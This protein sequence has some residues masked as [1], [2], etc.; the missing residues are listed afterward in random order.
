MRRPA[1]RR[2]FMA[3]SVIGLKRKIRY[4]KMVENITV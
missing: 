1:G 3:F 2:F 4:D